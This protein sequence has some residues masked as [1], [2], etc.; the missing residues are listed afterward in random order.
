MRAA[1]GNKDKIM[2][3]HLPRFALP[4]GLGALLNPLLPKFFLQNHKC[5]N[6]YG[7]CELCAIRVDPTH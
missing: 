7:L 1:T 6:F 4:T 5:E 3:K 2:A